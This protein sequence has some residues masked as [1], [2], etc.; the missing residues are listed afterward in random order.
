M[1]RQRRPHLHRVCLAT[2][3]E[4]TAMVLK[5]VWEVRH[6]ILLRL[7]AYL[8][9]QSGSWACP[10]S[11]RLRESRCWSCTDRRGWGEENQPGRRGDHRE[12]GGGSGWWS[13]TSELKTPSRRSSSRRVLL[14]VW[15]YSQIYL[16]CV[17]GWK[18][19]VTAQKIFSIYLTQNRDH[20]LVVRHHPP[21]GNIW[22][23]IFEKFY[24]FN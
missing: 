23:K 12:R 20:Y 3:Q 6:F 2:Q 19:D 13:S 9:R 21:T 4:I 14:P 7:P 10:G 8:C 15:E 16:R 11:S 24:R 5:S 22:Q 18:A 17:G 1:W